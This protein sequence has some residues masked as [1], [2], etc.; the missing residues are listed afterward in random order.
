MV[1]R[2]T[3]C[4]SC[5]CASAISA[6][7]WQKLPSTHSM[8]LMIAILLIAV[9][10]I[11]LFSSK[12]LTSSEALI[13]V[14][15][16]CAVGGLV[17]GVLWV[18]SVGHFYYSWQLP[19]GKIQQDVTISGQ[20]VSGGCVAGTASKAEAA[21]YYVARITSVNRKSTSE[22]LDNTLLSPSFNSVLSRVFNFRAR[23][24]HKRYEFHNNGNKQQA[25]PPI[26]TTN[27][28]HQYNSFECLHNGDT[29]TA[30][31][32]LKPAYGTANPI[33]ASRQQQLLSQFIHATGYIK[34]IE[35]NKTRHK[36]SV[37][38][39]LST[40]LNHLKLSNHA[41]WRALL[42]GE[43][44]G[45]TTE[46]WRLLQRTGTGHIFSISGMHLSLIAGVCLLAFN[47]IIFLLTQVFNLL[48][49]AEYWSAGVRSL[50]AKTRNQKGKARRVPRLLNSKAPIRTMVLCLLVFACFSYSLISGSALPVVRALI[51]LT[52]GCMLSLSR[53]A[54]RP[55]NIGLAM[56]TLSLLLFPLSM[57]SASFYLSVGAVVFIWFL[58]SILGSQRVP[59]Y[60]SLIKMQIALTL[61][62]MPLTLIWFGS[63]SVIALVANLIAL[64]VIT[65]LLPVCLLSL[66]LLHFVP[67]TS[68]QQLA[69]MLLQISDACLGHLLWLLNVL[70]EL[71]ISAI[72]IH[73]SSSAAICLIG[74]FVVYLLPAWRYKPLCIMLLSVPFVTSFQK[75]LP[76]NDAIWT[77]HVF[78]AGQAS[79]I[80]ITK[81]DRA[82]I[83][84]SGAQFNGIALTAT[85][86]LMPF[87]ES[88]HVTDVDVVIHTHSDNDHA[89]GLLAV[90]QHPL[91]QHATF[92]SPTQGCERGKQIR[93][94]ELTISFFW[95]P[96]GNKQDNNAMS[97][98]VKIS[99][100]TGSVLIPGDIEKASEYA[101]ITREINDTRK[102]EE[103]STT[104]GASLPVSQS[105]SANIL[106]A[107]HHGSKTSSTGIFIEHVA[108]E[109]VIF[110]QG[111]ENRWQF[112]A[113]DV[114]KRYEHKKVEQYLTSKHGYVRVTF[115]SRSYSIDTQRG[116][117][118]K[119]WY[120]RG[121]APR[122]LKG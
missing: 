19:Q 37:R 93:W 18:A 39:A 99:S 6:V 51:L 58:V 117:L 119:R 76:A 80:A 17:L 1:N 54:W 22:F 14:Q 32:K 3:I 116:T 33:G 20:V 64:P 98:V 61:I 94:Q 68:V 65:L 83:I 103:E 4:L 49:S 85:Q 2:I 45:F 47:P 57:L 23:L 69:S 31:V 53:N 67:F 40:T 27:P 107:P 7:F 52:V 15:L 89:G 71:S 110:T 122:H 50:E 90:K 81:G 106:I 121:I 101:L 82:I 9:L 118:Q 86:H 114:A 73:V 59:W 56:L 46:N 11:L 42:L 35:H 104:E 30:V 48:V 25:Q 28:K 78:D 102:I 97:C 16:S 109:A 21:F 75:W 29:F 13:D 36:H 77:L 95:P 88:T 120:L 12:R 115:N 87:L 44:S 63:A 91:A 60:V 105:L 8:A 10:I 96:N 66:L 113:S 26:E 100:E 5:F 84:D 111:F 70:S 41:W 24:S 55:V 79:A 112:P 34:S 38:Y 43:K 74:A 62:M 72:N 108:P 92:F